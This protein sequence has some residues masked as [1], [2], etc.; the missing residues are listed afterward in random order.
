[1]R[2]YSI[3]SRN[4]RKLLFISKR[5]SEN[6]IRRK[7]KSEQGSRRKPRKMGLSLMKSILK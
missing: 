1:M 3:K 2:T 5:N 4:E 6:E 7:E